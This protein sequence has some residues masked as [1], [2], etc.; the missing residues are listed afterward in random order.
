M[1]K[2]LLHQ[3]NIKNTYETHKRSLIIFYPNIFQV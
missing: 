2:D 3:I 1:N